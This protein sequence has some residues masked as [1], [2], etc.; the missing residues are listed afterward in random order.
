MEF[1]RNGYK[2]NTRLFECGHYLAFFAL[3]LDLKRA[4]Q[5]PIKF[6]FL[7]LWVD[8]HVFLALALCDSFFWNRF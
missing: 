2:A 5:G 1:G 4:H 7:S 6:F 8:Y 3:V